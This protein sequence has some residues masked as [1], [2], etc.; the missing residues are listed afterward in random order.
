MGLVF[1]EEGISKLRPA[2]KQLVH[3]AARITLD[4]FAGDLEAD[5]TVMDDKRA[6]GQLSCRQKCALQVRYG[7][8]VIL[9]QLLRMTQT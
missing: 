9:H 3:G 7:Q 2:W 6:Y 8:K 1:S 4:S 5:K